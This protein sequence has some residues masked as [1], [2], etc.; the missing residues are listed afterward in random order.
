MVVMDYDLNADENQDNRSNF[1]WI[2]ALRE[3]NEVVF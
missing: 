2:T 3:K 1:L